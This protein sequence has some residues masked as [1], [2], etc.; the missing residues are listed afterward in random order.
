MATTLIAVVN[1]LHAGSTVAICP[2]RIELDDGG[3]YEASKAQRWLWQSWGAYW[4]AV[5]AKRRELGARL[6]IVFNGDLFDGDH[7]NTPQILSRNP[8]AQSAVLRECLAIPLSLNPD[9]LFFVRGTEAHVGKS[10][11]GEEGVARRLRDDGKPVQGDPAAGTASWWHLRMD[12][13][14]IRFDVAH[15]G[16]TGHRAHTEGNAANLYAH[17]ILLQHIKDGDR[18]PDIALRAH[19]HRFNDS[20]DMCPVRVITNGAWQLKTGFVHKVAADSMS[21]IGG[22]MAW[23]RDGKYGVEK[24][25]YKAERG[26]VWSE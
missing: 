9:K 22:L 7:H 16:R 21:H 2:P 11:S 15:H 12:V 24:I 8:E 23:V 6:F 10:A 3:A 26:P 4:D 19:Y 20:Y 1:D 13:D 18:P 25:H 17:D 5:E 14:G